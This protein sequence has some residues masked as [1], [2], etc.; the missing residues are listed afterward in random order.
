M[1]RYV[2]PNRDAHRTNS[3]GRYLGPDRGGKVHTGYTP[4]PTAHHGGHGFWN[5]VGQFGTDLKN[6]AVNSPDAAYAIGQA[7]VHD[8]TAGFIHPTRKSH[9]S[10]LAGIGKA[11]GKATIHDFRHPLAHPGNTF[12]DTLGIVGGGAGVIGRVGLAGKELGTAG[13]VSRVARAGKR[14]VTRPVQ[15]DRYVKLH[16]SKPVLAGSYSR[17]QALAM[18]QKM[19]DKLRESHPNV[20]VGR[21]T[22]VTRWGDA[23]V[24]QQNRLNDLEKA[25]GSALVRKANSVRID[26][27]FH[28]RINPFKHGLSSAQQKAIQVVGEGVAINKRIDFHK[29]QLKVL[30]KK[31]DI[32]RTHNEINLLQAA[33]RYVHSAS[34]VP[35]IRAAFP[36]LQDITKNAENLAKE[37]ESILTKSGALTDTTERLHAPGRIITGDENFAG[38]KFRV[39]YSRKRGVGSSFRIGPNKTVGIGRKPGSL[40]HEFTGDILKTGGGRADISTLMAESHLEAQRYGAQLRA[41]DFILKNSKDTAEGMKHPVAVRE[42]W[43]KNKTY[44][45]KVNEI[46]SKQ[47]AGIKLSA[48]EKSDLFN[49]HQNFQKNFFDENILPTSEKQ[50]GVKWI[51]RGQLGGMDRPNPLVGLQSYPAMQHTLN[52]FDAINN[53]SRAAILYLKPAYAAPNIVGNAALTLAQQ[54][55]AAPHNLWGAARLNARLGAEDAAKVDEVVGAGI[56]AA[57]KSNTG[58]LSKTTQRAGNL[59]EKVVDQPF[60]RASFLYEAGK[61]GFHTPEEIHDLLNSPKFRK[62][63]HKVTDRANKELIDYGNMGPIERE[64][65]RRII[66]FY[67]W[68]KG[69][70]VYAGR[71]VGEHPVQ[72]AVT[73]QMG[74]YGAEKSDKD[75]GLRPG[76]AEAMYKSGGGSGNIIKTLNPSSASIL[77]TPADIA[78]ALTGQGFQNLASNY[79]PALQAL[80]TGTAGIDSLGRKVKGNT[81]AAAAK[82][83]YQGLPLYVLQDRLRHAQANKTFPM[84]KRQAI[85]IYLLSTAI[86]SRNTNLYKVNK[87]GYSQAHPHP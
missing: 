87:S 58:L 60:R 84:T 26:Q 48:R 36:A 24:K 28:E 31:S 77:Q 33:K 83:L 54:G 67:P 6:A 5:T 22:Q 68:V 85:E 81:W 18:G 53:A 66:F 14:L 11:M 27:K 2:A 64:F 51:E 42:D 32:N 71:F 29:K 46:L 52:T 37:R 75:I 41:R 15:G 78:Q 65:I 61:E 74:K 80:Y 79:T 59:W 9:G 13:E 70:T 49:A 47:E 39:P 4:T 10:E 50:T 86:A 56:T 1:G 17:N 82:Q 73:G 38:G 35:T 21:K 23:F 12:L 45:P 19:V 43:Y 16:G 76:W 3:S 7:A 44:S 63:L 72:A 34:G 57:L 8:V 69:S 55:F 30:T 40:T 25:K 62:D 20:P